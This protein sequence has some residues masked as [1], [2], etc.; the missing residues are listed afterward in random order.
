MAITITTYISPP[1][2][3]QMVTPAYPSQPPPYP[4]TRTFATD[5]DDDDDDE[6]D[7][8]HDVDDDDDCCENIARVP[9][10]LGN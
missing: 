2:Q 7:A 10:G 9:A 3:E 6:D 8:D 1:G 4:T 5:D